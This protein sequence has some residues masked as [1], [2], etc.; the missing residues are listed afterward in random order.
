[1]IEGRDGLP[2][3][4]RV[5]GTAVP[6][7]ELATVWIFGPMTRPALLIQTQIRP[8]KVVG[9]SKLSKDVR[10]LDQ[11]GGVAGSA[12]GLLV[13]PLQGIPG[14]A[15]GK[16]VRVHPDQG[17][18]FAQMLFMAGAAILFRESPMVTPLLFYSPPQ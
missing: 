11:A 3:S 6:A 9:H 1:M 15:M 2:L 18:V 17:K 13:S 8:G 14:P 5:A 7:G 16:R 10:T 12:R 4:F